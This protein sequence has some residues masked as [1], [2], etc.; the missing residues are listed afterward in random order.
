MRRDWTREL[1]VEWFWLKKK[2][3]R[4]W[5]LDTPVGVLGI[6]IPLVGFLLFAILAQGL[7]DFFRIAIPWVSGGNI[8]TV[9][10]QS[11]GFGIKA[12]FLFLLFVVIIVAYTILK[13]MER[14]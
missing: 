7:S 6:L 3:V 12:S 4:K 1:T 11:I 14:R 10:W 13:I 2:I 9:Y 8:S 5:R